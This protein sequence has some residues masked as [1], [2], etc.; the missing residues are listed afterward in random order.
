MVQFLQVS[1]SLILFT[2]KILVLMG[3]KSGWLIG[4]IGCALAIIYLYL[5][6]LYVFTAL[7]IGLIV[8]MLY[9]YFVKQNK[10]I[11]IENT[12]RIVIILSMMAISYFAFAGLL[13]VFELISS[14]GLLFGT[15][16]LTHNKTTLGWLLYC[17]GHLITAYIGYNKGQD[18]FADFQ[19]AS[20]IVSIMGI[21]KKN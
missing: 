1:V 9:G 18:F 2:N 15:Y 14:A 11:H 20:A 3:R 8:L 19:I 16:Y 6:E 13:T 10:N 21:I 5:I 4:A 12:I 17:I 7:E